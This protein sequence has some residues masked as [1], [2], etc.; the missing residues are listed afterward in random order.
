MIIKPVTTEKA[1]R[2]IEIDNTILFQVGS[3]NNKKDF[4]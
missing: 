3:K 4:Q 1:I 2:L